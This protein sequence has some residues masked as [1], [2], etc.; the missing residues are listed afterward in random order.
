MG[1]IRIFIIALLVAVIVGGSGLFY[2]SNFVLP[3]KKVQKAKAIAAAA[4]PTPTPDY[5]I[6]EF[7][8]IKPLQ[9]DGKTQEAR[10][11]YLAFIE[12]FPNSSKLPDAK[13][14]IGDLNIQM[15]FSDFRSPDKQEYT[16][17][18]GDAMVKIASKTK[19][20]VDLIYRANNMSSINLQIG[21][22]L[23]IP[24]VQPSIK[25][26]RKA[27]TL[28][29][30]DNGKLLK[31]YPIVSFKG[32]GSTGNNVTAQVKEKA[33]LQA[34]KRVAFGAKEYSG[35]DRWVMLSNS[36]IIIKSAPTPQEGTEVVYPAGI[37]LD[38]PDM[39][40]VFVLVNKGTPVS[41]D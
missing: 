14:A 12:K 4:V 10:D 17:I 13:K 6:A 9:D 38:R 33:S 7:D 15:L 41:I 1:P 31:E 16:V 11:A 2:Y 19:T 36:G 22:V 29:L 3:R 23:L 35:S 26:N 27:K 37:V 21:Q 8:K 18:K 39:D 34:D 24:K 25:V 30:F 32:S 5:S 40:E 20:S 28:T